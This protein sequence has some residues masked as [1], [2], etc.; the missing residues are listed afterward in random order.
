[1]RIAL[2]LL[3]TNSL[4]F[5]DPPA[6]APTIAHVCGTR[7]ANLDAP[8]CAT[9]VKK[10]DVAPYDAVALDEQENVRRT[11]ALAGKAGTIDS[12]QSKDVLI[13]KGVLATIITGC[14]VLAAAA[15]GAG[16]Y[17]ATKK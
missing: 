14:I 11:R 12:A 10:G 4:A 7:E 9:L 5:A 16:V 17:L 6:D 3:L 13:P 8:G 15:G 2:A 1:M